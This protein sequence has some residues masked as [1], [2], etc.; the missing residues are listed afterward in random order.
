[1]KSA[2]VAV[3]LGISLLWASDR[4]KRPDI[5]IITNANVVDVRYGTVLPNATIV[6]KNGE[7]DAIAKF[8]VLDTGPNVHVVNAGGGY[9]I[10][11]LWDMDAHFSQ[12]TAPGWDNHSLF[13]DYLAN[14]VIGLREPGNGDDRI[15]L[16]SGIKE[17][18]PHDPL[19]EILPYLHSAL[20]AHG[21]AE[22]RTIEG[23]DEVM[24]ACSSKEDELRHKPAPAPQPEWE[25]PP[26]P[27]GRQ[28]RASY[29]PQ[30]AESLFLSVSNHGTWMVPT[31]VSLEAPFAQ[32]SGDDWESVTDPFT[33]KWSQSQIAELVEEKSKFERARLLVH[34]MRSSGVQFLAG[35]GGPRK[36]LPPGRSLHRELKLLVS[37]GFSPL[38]AIRTATINAALY[39]AKLNKYG[40]VETGH[41]AD[42]VLTDG[43]PAEDIN[44]LEKITGVVMNGNYFS[45]ADLDRFSGPGRDSAQHTKTAAVPVAKPAQQS[46]ARHQD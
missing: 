1:M 17:R 23:V 8:A 28:I 32:F 43:N 14:G 42:L 6:I 39:I 36:E 13:S 38:D 27:V 31:L 10:P 33:I 40:V 18:G 41:V 22:Q 4:P 3:L 9:V 35:T 45:R 29:D 24:L 5:L 16:V 15:Q 2:V 7:I 26:E 21:L 11:G 20:P 46:G 44:N 30:K 12:A 37:S 19:G 25:A 34:D